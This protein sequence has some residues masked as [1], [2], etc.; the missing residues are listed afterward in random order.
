MH[1][2][3]S[4]IGVEEDQRQNEW[5]EGDSTEGVDEEEAT[6]RTHGEPVDQCGRVESSIVWESDL[7]K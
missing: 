6:E 3:E 7:Q 5:N 2:R 1:G 4:Q